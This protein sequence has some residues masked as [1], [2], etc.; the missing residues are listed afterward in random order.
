MDSQSGDFLMDNSSGDFFMD[1]PSGDFCV[2]GCVAW[3]FWRYDHMFIY[4]WMLRCFAPI[5]FLLLCDQ[6]CTH[7]GNGPE[8]KAG[9]HKCME[10]GKPS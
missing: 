6:V 8:N 2:R 9:A 4:L 7:H 3:V 10:E 5:C 1:S